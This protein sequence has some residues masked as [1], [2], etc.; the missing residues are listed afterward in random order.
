[1]L[2]AMTS[3]RN[4]A[5]AAAGEA[6]SG[7]AHALRSRVLSLLVAGATRSFI[8]N[9]LRVSP[10]VV[11]ACAVALRREL[12]ATTQYSLGVQAVRSRRVPSEFVVGNA[13][14]RTDW[15]GWTSPTARQVGIL[16]QL[17]D[18]ATDEVAAAR[19]GVSAR[20]IRREATQVA[21]A[22]GVHGRVAAGALFETLGWHQLPDP[23]TPPAAS[24]AT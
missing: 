6:R 12:A 24:P 23:L 17:A 18:G 7:S 14:R 8:A 16:R 10:H 15:R 2:P 21:S 13:Q 1:M 3:D 11:D 5:V 19:L 20:T 22:N 9:S 4:S